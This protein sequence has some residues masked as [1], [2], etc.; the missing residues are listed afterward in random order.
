MNLQQFKEKK[1]KK[2][3]QFCIF[4]KLLKNVLFGFKYLKTEM[5]SKQ[6]IKINGKKAKTE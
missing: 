5:Y 3:G 1:C 2:W 4:F 6:Y